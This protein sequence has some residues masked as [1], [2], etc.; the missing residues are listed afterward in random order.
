[1]AKSTT[2]SRN[3]P[4]KPLELQR[5]SAAQ[6]DKVR[7]RVYMSPEECVAVIADSALLAM[8]LSGIHS[9]Y[10]IVRDLPLA[11]HA[12]EKDELVTHEQQ[13]TVLMRPDAPQSKILVFEA[14]TSGKPITEKKFEPLDFAKKLEKPPIVQKTIGLSESLESLAEVPATQAAAASIPEGVSADISALSEESSPV[15][16]AADTVEAAASSEE[17]LDPDEINRLLN[18]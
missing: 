2:E 6:G 3:R 5:K 10:R 14:A 17:A 8:K 18:G 12:V 15:P 13:A 11:K 7:Y 1:M 9:P 4:I 16:A